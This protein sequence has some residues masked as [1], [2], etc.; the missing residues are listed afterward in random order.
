MPQIPL[1]AASLGSIGGSDEH[2]GV[3]TGHV[4]NK[5]SQLQRRR[6]HPHQQ[7]TA[8]TAVDAEGLYRRPD[9]L[10]VDICVF[11]VPG[12]HRDHDSRAQLTPRCRPPNPLSRPST[13]SALATRMETQLW[14][15]QE[16][17]SREVGSIFSVILGFDRILSGYTFWG[18]GNNTAEEP[19]VSTVPSPFD[20]TPESESRCTA[21]ASLSELF[22]H[23]PFQVSA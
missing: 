16:I 7:C 21:S 23:E 18:T 4:G 2:G 9:C 15:P 8:A 5:P 19:F 20:L 1:D 6:E 22:S 10:V 13:S 17:P 12:N 14:S 11:G 3:W